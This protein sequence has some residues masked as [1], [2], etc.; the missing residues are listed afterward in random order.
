MLYHCDLQ[1]QSSKCCSRKSRFWRLQWNVQF[2]RGRIP[3]EKG[4][5]FAVQGLV[6]HFQS[7]EPARREWTLMNSLTSSKICDFEVWGFDTRRTKHLSHENATPVVA[8][9]ERKGFINRIG[10]GVSVAS[11]VLW[12]VAVSALFLPFLLT[13]NSTAV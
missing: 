2:S 8:G 6:N 1:D 5:V 11:S 4:S 9:V 3:L 12:S 7:A 10:F 13:A